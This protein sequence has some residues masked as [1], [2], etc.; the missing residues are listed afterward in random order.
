MN[1]KVTI[2]TFLMVAALGACAPATT[3]RDKE[4]LGRAIF[5]DHSLS[6][7]AGM[8]CVT[9]HRPERGFA[10]T[11][12]RVTSESIH[13][14]LFAKRNSMSISYS[15]YVPHLSFSASDSVFF[16]GLFWDGRAQ[17]LSAQAGSPFIDM[18][19][20]RN[21]SPSAVAVKLRRAPYF[22]Q[23]ERIYGHSGSD[24]EL[25]LR[26]TDA[27]AAYQRSDEVNPFS[28][29]FDLCQAG[30]LALDPLEAE[31]FELFKG[32]GLCAECH[33]TDLD[34]QA[35]RIL[36]TDHTYDN[37]G[38]PANPENR[39][40]QMPL[41]HNPDSTAW[42]DPGLGAVLGNKMYGGMFRVPTLRNIA[43]TAPYAHN[44]YFKTLDDI[45]HFYNVRD[46]TD[47]YPPAEYAENVN[48]AEMGDL[49]L[50]PTEEAAIVAFLQTLS[51]GYQH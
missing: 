11:L 50:T 17:S 20:M 5:F 14:G 31:G 23:F 48:R 16:G 46:V 43:L 21:E 39:F 33:I 41:H 44:G 7:P 13:E 22:A 47:Q 34:P 51:D 4:L 42:R 3:D 29:K 35:G 18:L 9:C 25:F 40:Y 2:F 27:L 24:E 6:E 45:V 49:G 1:C 26:A 38:V 8:A 19:E 37:L 28:S 36:F 30:I 10:D 32:K 12:S 15:A